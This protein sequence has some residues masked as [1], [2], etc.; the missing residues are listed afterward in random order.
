MRNLRTVRSHFR[1]MTPCSSGAVRHEY[2]VRQG[3]EERN[4]ARS[5]EM[6]CFGRGCRALRKIR[7][8]K[9]K[10]D[11][12]APSRSLR[13]NTWRRPRRCSS[14]SA[15]PLSSPTM[16]FRRSRRGSKPSYYTSWLLLR[17]VEACGRSGDSFWLF[18]QG[19]FYFFRLF[20]L[21]RQN[22]AMKAI[23][24]TRKTDP[25]YLRRRR[26]HTT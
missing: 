21:L 8:K 25:L 16:G 17:P 3:K 10:N 2:C 9:I 22:V 14:L 18:F 12:H 1:R 11:H 24:R 4:G 26:T 5:C 23:D 19:V 13:L 7:N 20:L 6:S 15:Q